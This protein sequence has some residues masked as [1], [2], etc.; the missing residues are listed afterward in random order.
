MIHTDVLHREMVILLERLRKMR[1]DIE[2]LEGELDNIR[3]SGDI[4]VPPHVRQSEAVRQPSLIFGT[5]SE[6]D[7]D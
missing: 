4:G 2:H 5:G 1:N 7:F 6:E 3:T